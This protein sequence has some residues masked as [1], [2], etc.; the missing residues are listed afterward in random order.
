MD[1]LHLLLLIV[2]N[3]MFANN[4]AIVILA[5]EAIRSCSCNYVIQFFRH[6]R[7]KAF[8]SVVILA[9]PQ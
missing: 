9:Y 1:L 3:I 5:R 7:K 2:T 6:G 8:N 4:V